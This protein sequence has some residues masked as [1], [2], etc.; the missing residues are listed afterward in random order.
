MLLAF[1]LPA[2]L[3]CTH[4]SIWV[5]LSVCWVKITFKL[6]IIVCARTQLAAPTPPSSVSA[7]K[8]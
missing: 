4:A 8:T 6:K 7:L 5:Y 2:V 3:S 1:G